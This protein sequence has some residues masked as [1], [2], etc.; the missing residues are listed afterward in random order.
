VPRE[1]KREHRMGAAVKTASAARV[2]QT[3]VASIDPG[4]LIGLAPA[5]VRE[6][7]GPPLRVESSDLSREWVYASTGCSFR[8][9][10]YP[11]LNTAAFRVLKYG[12]NDGNG[13][14]IAV[15]DV[16]IQHILTA[17]KNATG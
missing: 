6:L 15:S 9:F 10:F 1:K 5:A 7:L 17:R 11:N 4:R 16:C 2:A 8:L 3:R 12:S 14:L 13:E